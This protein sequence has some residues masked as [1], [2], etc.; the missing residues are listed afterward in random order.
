M[1]MGNEF[2][3]RSE[4]RHEYSLD[5]HLLQYEY[6][7]GIQKWV[8][9]LNQLYKSENA[10]HDYDHNPTGFEW[11]DANDSQ[12]SVYSF[13]RKSHNNEIILVLI[14]CTPI[15]RLMYR[16]GVPSSQKWHLLVSSDDKDF[17]GADRFPKELIAE[18]VPFHGREHSLTL[19]IPGLS[20]GFYKCT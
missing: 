15:S 10:L 20:M 4:W 2:G 11:I 7:A 14:N 16:V 3:Q 13:L 9:R 8:S 17:G 19:D 5:W 1:F 6:H 18:S 12:N